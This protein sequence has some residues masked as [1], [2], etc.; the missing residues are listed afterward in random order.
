PDEHGWYRVKEVVGGRTRVYSTRALTRTQ[1][2]AKGPASDRYG[3]P[4]PPKFP[5]KA[6]RPPATAD[7]ATD[8]SEPNKEADK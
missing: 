4:L 7:E 1:Q 2:I 6:T 5:S 8:T 3:N